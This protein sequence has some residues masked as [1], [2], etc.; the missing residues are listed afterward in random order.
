MKKIIIGLV[1]F[2]FAVNIHSQNKQVQ[3][4]EKTTITTIKDSEGEKT[5]VKKENIQQEQ[6]IELQ[7]AKA[8]TLN[9]N[10]KETPVE[11]T[12]VV[13][14]TNPDGST[15]TVDVDRSAYYIYNGKRY[16]IALDARGYKITSDEDKKSALLRETTTNSY[17]YRA[18]GQT[19]IGYFDTNGNLIL[20]TYDDKLDKVKIRTYVP[21]K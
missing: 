8:R 12:K 15:R 7:R 5:A 1:A 13:T 14:V 3:A 10:I 17:I 20:E 6:K 18:D 19:S 21:V 11:V 4:E 2:L 16:K 9:K